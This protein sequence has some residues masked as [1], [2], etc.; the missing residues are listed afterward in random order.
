MLHEWPYG[1]KV[2]YMRDYVRVYA[3]PHDIVR[4]VSTL[5]KD[6]EEVLKQKPKK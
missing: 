4:T 1:A 2:A 5:T 3:G 6:V